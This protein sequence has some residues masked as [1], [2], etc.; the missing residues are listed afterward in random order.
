M[1]LALSAAVLLVLLTLNV[2]KKQK[3][4]KLCTLVYKIYKE[5]TKVYSVQKIKKS[6]RNSKKKLYTFVH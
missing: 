6:V 3:N 1:T 2:N 5:C 4:K